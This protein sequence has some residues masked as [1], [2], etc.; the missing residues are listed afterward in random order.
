MYKTFRLYR[1]S[2]RTIVNLTL[3]ISFLSI[4][5]SCFAKAQDALALSPT[6]HV[7]NETN[8]NDRVFSLPKVMH[9]EL[10]KN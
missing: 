1:F 8:I 5:Q 2:S 4:S 6:T 9:E 10:M 3:A 7:E